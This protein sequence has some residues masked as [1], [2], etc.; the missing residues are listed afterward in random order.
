MFLLATTE[1]NAGDTAWMLVSCALV[2]LMTPG[3]ALFYGGMVQQKN[4]LSTLVHSFF[5][6]GLVTFAWV[7][8]GYSLAFGGS[9]GGWI[10]N[11]DHALL[12]GVGMEP[13]EGQT[14]P[15][16]V[17]MMFQG[18][19]AI[20][21]PAL[22][23]GAYAERMKFSAY[24]VFTL[25][26]SLLVYSPI[27]HWVWAPEGWLLKRGALDFAGGTVVHL[28]S[29][30]AAL[31]AAF[32]VGKRVG[33]PQSRHMPHNLTMTLIG[34]GLLWFGWF[35]FNGGSA[36]ASNGLAGLS[37]V[38]THLGAA[39][40]ALGWAAVEYA[41]IKKVT[42][43][44]VASGLV[45]GLVGITPAAGFVSPMSACAIGFL[46]GLVCYG[47]VLL[48][49]RFGYDDALDAFGVHGVGGIFGAILTGIFASKIWNEAGQDGLIS[50]NFDLLVEQVI[51]IA[52]AGAFS[53]VLTFVLLKLI[54]KTIGLRPTTD[55]EREGLDVN[56]HG[57]T[58]YSLGGSPMGHAAR[59][60]D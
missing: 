57:E 5:A 60:G 19:F 48:K 28:S 17:F 18:M 29:G 22:I 39:F 40:G 11:L 43:L 47:G 3:L 12:A 52:V 7:T 50:G 35:G 54:D 56:L 10:G 49:H 33:Y 26:W 38:N 24:L 55:D 25:L 1:I 59:D 37:F 20:I 41:R 13:R 36:I 16:L 58:G 45:A 6:L 31:V 34:A 46:T 2:M 32:V 30:I 42:A 21:T 14:I 8:V 51:G 53:A 27:A 4:V 23:S 15:H 44:G 9:L